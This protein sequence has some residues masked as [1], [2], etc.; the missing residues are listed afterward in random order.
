MSKTQISPATLV[1]ATFAGA[2]GLMLLSGPFAWLASIAGLILLLTLLSYD[3]EAY[4]SWFQSVAFSAVCS[5][6][7]MIALGAVFQL[8]AARGEIHL[9]NGRWS[10]EWMPI[11]FIFATAIFFGI[12]RIRMSSREPLEMRQARRATAPQPGFIPR[13]VYAPAPSPEIPA[14]ETLHRLIQEE[15]ARAF[16]DQQPGAVTE[17]ASQPASV[18]VAPVPHDTS[19]ATAEAKP[20]AAVP[21]AAAS[22]P[23]AP[24]PVPVNPTPVPAAPARVLSQPAPAETGP[25]LVSHPPV[26]PAIPPGKEAMIY[27]S[28]VGE[29][30]NV[31][32]SVRAEHL[33]KDF[34]RIVETVPEGET[35]EFQPGQV[36]RC[37]KKNLSGGK[38]LVA[39]EE[40]PK[41]HA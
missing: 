17:P 13:A 20:V 25:T 8:L 30:M 11:G 2:L 26:T 14:A 16:A 5:F 19:A 40:A 41:A 3:Q 6:C 33:S 32:R 29:G 18:Q 31:L 10:T 1:A 23:V 35:W 36:V 22:V 15:V 4:R 38:A 24:A 34:Y 12:D 9:A 39:I 27:V 7:C 37:K 21:V 28:L